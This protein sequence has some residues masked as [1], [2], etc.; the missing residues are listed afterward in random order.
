MWT[1]CLLFFQVALLLGY[2]YAHLVGRAR[3]PKIH[4]VALTLALALLGARIA[5]WPSPI[6]FSQAWAP[7]GDAHPSLMILG[8]LLFTI[9]PPFLVLSATGPLLQ[10]WYARC[11]PGESPYRLYA[12]S[13]IGSLVG[14]VSYPFV[15]EP[16]LSVTDQGWLWSAGFCVFTLGCIRTAFI[17]RRASTH[18]PPPPSA[19]APAEPPNARAFGLWFL[20]AMLASIL[21]L[22]VT[23]QIAAEVAVIP[24][25]WMLPLALYLLSFVLC[26]EY[27][28]AY[29]RNVWVPL[30]LVGGALTTIVIIMGVSAPVLV[31]LGVY[32][33]TLLFACMVCHGELVRRKPAPR[34]LTG[35]YLAVAAGGA[36]GGLFTAIVAPTIFVGYWELPLALVATCALALALA[37]EQWPVR[38]LA[39]LLGGLYI[40]AM[41][42]A[43]GWRARID[44]ADTIHTSRGFFG[45]LR[46]DINDDDGELRMRLRHGRITHGFQLVD[47][48]LAYIPTSYYGP[49]SGIT[50]AI[51]THPRRT[52]GEPLHIAVVG[53]GTGTMASHTI[54][55]DHL[56]FY[57]IDPDVVALSTGDDPLFTYVRDALGEVEVTMGDARMNLER[58]PDQ[59]F[60]ILAVDAFSSDAIPAHLLTVEALRVYVRH[61]RDRER[62]PGRSTSRTATSTSTR[63]C[64]ARRRSW[65]FRCC[66]STTSRTKRRTT[67]PATGC[68]WPPIRR[69]SKGC[70]P[71]RRPS[72]P[73][74]AS[75][76]GRPGR[77]GT[78][79]SSRSSS[80]PAAVDQ[81]SSAPMSGLSM[82]GSPSMSWSAASSP[83]C[84]PRVDRLGAGD[85]VGVAAQR[86]DEVVEVHILQ[87]AG[88]RHPG[89]VAVEDRVGDQVV[90][91]LRLGPAE[92]VLDRAQR[93]DR[94][95]HRVV[96]HRRVADLP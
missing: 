5:F 44:L 18:P 38:S 51:A 76:P 37:R 70:A 19:E 53:L 68:S 36:G 89:I 61:L 12:V 56:R 10:A 87:V 64:A 1:T 92:A 49:G 78:A 32:L 6:T 93:L 95:G 31:Q 86:V 75:P 21:L 58:E 45:L 67:R 40:V 46:V 24:F 9:G 30:L 35:F 84:T 71:W 91:H 94:R 63:S 16:L 57:E 65:G 13:N 15:V 79:T 85:E 25:L 8:L 43:L 69:R 33:S 29:R 50:L 77:T 60:D 41:T 2:V 7:T 90:E 72:N 3:S 39:G 34:H 81:Y 28:R 20:L 11:F 62:R 26:F 74:R 27:T 83:S 22:A 48:D 80:R 66:G 54:D 47:P 59:A 23:S 42:G 55:G 82:R 52:H 96:H 17:V 14:L 73:R 4:L 88:D